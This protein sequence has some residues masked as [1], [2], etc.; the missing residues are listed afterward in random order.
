TA[1]KIDLS[2]MPMKKMFAEGGRVETAKP[3]EGGAELQQRSAEAVTKIAIEHAVAGGKMVVPPGP[4]GIP[5]EHSIMTK[6]DSKNTKKESLGK[7]TVEGVEAEGSRTTITI[8][9][10]EIGNEAPINIVSEMWYS[11]ELQTVVMSKHSDPRMGENT[12]RLTNI[13][14]TEP[15]RSLFEV[16]SDYTIKEMPGLPPQVRF[17]IEKEARR[18]NN[19]K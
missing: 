10:G 7:Q 6:I 12:Y 19:D 2:A 5:F 17:N 13:S 4:P 1:R 9:A 18:P 16:P 11:P 15:A 8:A 14:R 3:R